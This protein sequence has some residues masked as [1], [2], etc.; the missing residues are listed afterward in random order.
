MSVRKPKDV[1]Y[2]VTETGCHECTSH[3]PYTSGYCVI[4]INGKRILLH[5]Y[6]YIETFGPIKAG[7]VIRHTCDNTLCINPNHL[8]EG[9]NADNSRDMVNRNRS[10]K[11]IRNAN[12]KLTE[13]QV[14]E[15]FNS[16]D[17]NKELAQKYNTDDTTIWY[18]K[19]GK[20]WGHLTKTI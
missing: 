3:K 12:S 19:A 11:G 20:R 9:T 7:N 6:I 4:M 10:G 15:I 16:T 5:R 1:T 2:K 18:I 14:I 13:Q 17:S 8:V